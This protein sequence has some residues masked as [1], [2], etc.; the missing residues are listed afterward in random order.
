MKTKTLIALL[1]LCPALHADTIYFTGVSNT[2]TYHYP[3]G[4]LLYPDAI[5]TQPFT[6]IEAPGEITSVSMTPLFNDGLDN[7]FP[8]QILISTDRQ[9]PSY[10]VFQTPLRLTID[11]NGYRAPGSI[12]VAVASWNNIDYFFLP[13]AYNYNQEQTITFGFELNSITFT[14]VP[15]PDVYALLLVGVLF[16]IAGRIVSKKDHRLK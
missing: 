13:R 3:W 14:P 15:E 1:F 9:S 8:F 6:H 11:V 4:E 16:L 12:D 5:R 10:P 7:F 2:W